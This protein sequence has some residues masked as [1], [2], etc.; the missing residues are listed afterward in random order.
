M[1]KRNTKLVES[2]NGVAQIANL[3]KSGM[4]EV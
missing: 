4:G 3:D 2:N 1:M